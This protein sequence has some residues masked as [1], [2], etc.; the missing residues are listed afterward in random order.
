MNQPT[1]D[2]AMLWPNR[3]VCEQ[4]GRQIRSDFTEATR[5][6]ELDLRNRCAACCGLQPFLPDESRHSTFARVAGNI[7]RA[8]GWDGALPLAVAS[9]PPFVKAFLPNAGVGTAVTCALIVV[10]AAL[11]RSHLGARQIARVCGGVVPFLRQISLAAAIV[12]LLLFEA[13]V[14]IMVFGQGIPAT[15]WWFPIAF[16]VAYVVL[17]ALSFWPRSS[18][19]VRM[20]A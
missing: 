15:G 18:R 3:I 2:V 4:C 19:H 7:A 13:A 5:D 8:L 11:F 14:G 17:I 16:Y 1:D 10:F 6:G 20:Y 9:V 12:M